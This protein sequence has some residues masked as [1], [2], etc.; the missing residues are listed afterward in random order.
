MRFAAN[1]LPPWYPVETQETEEGLRKWIGTYLPT[2]Q[3][4]TGLTFTVIGVCRA[5]VEMA[6]LLHDGRVALAVLPDDPGAPPSKEDPLEIYFFDNV[7]GLN[8][9]I[10]DD[11]AEHQ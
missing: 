1:F 4:L 8:R 5:R 11:A 7:D 10:A 6:I 9:F 3:A 2:T